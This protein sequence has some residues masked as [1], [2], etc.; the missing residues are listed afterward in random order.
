MELDE[1]IADGGVIFGRGL[2]EGWDAGRNRDA[3]DDAYEAVEF[4][5]RLSMERR[6]VVRFWG[7][8]GECDDAD[9][10]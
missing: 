3:A 4:D 2:F 6:L 1:I 10:L 8:D 5:I 7:P 9:A